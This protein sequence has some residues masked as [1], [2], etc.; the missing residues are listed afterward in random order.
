VDGESIVRDGDESKGL[1]L[2]GDGVLTAAGRRA[3]TA[4][5]AL[6]ETPVTTIGGFR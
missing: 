4:T 6:W 5:A 1:A 3:L 2:M